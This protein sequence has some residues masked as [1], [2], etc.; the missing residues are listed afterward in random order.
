M[1]ELSEEAKAARRAY[2]REYMRRWR[3]A[4]KERDAENSRRYWERKAMKMKQE[5][6]NDE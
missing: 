6:K 4:N 2:N 1:N 5:G 3:A